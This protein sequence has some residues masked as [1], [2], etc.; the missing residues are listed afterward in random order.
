MQRCAIDYTG[1]GDGN[2]THVISLEGY[3]ST[4]EL[5]P[6]T[7]VHRGG[8]RKIKAALP[9]Q[10]Q[11]TASVA[12]FAALNLTDVLAAKVIVSPVRGLRP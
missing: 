11:L 1:A 6:R 7:S 3:G 12:A 10:N 9:T 8:E 4:I 2:R 5:R